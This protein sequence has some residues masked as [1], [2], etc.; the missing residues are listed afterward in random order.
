MSTDV[1][2]VSVLRRPLLGGQLQIAVLLDE[3]AKC[4]D[5]SRAI[6]VV[7]NGEEDFCQLAFGVRLRG[8]VLLETELYA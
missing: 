3:G 2:F 7:V 1:A 4:D 6:P 5:R 8:D